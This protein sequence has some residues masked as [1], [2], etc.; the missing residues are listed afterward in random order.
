MNL[1]KL[2]PQSRFAIA[3]GASIGFGHVL[4]RAFT[5]NLGPF[6]GLLAGVTVTAA[7][8]VVISLVLERSVKK[9][10]DTESVKV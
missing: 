3:V 6:A 4:M 9:Q 5:T 10:L 7:I 8:A 1:A 2:S